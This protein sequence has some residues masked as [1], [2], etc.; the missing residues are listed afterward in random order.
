MHKFKAILRDIL[1]VSRLTKIPRKKV[2]I[3]FS[4]LVSNG[5]GF[6]D[7]FII[8][9]FSKF[10]TDTVIG[11]E[12]LDTITSS[13]RIIPLVVVFRYL[14]NFIGKYNIFSLTK[15][16]EAS[17]KTYILDEVYKKGNY[18]LADA[19]YYIEQL[20][21]H[22]AYFFNAAA[23]IT[24]SLIQIFVFTT[25]LSYDN[26][27]VLL[28][29][30]FLVIALFFPSKF[31]LTKSRQAMEQSY[32]YAYKHVSYIQRII[33]NIFLVKILNTHKKELIKFEDN[34][35]KFYKTEKRKYILNDINVTIPNFIAVMSFSILLI[36]PR[37]A[38]SITLE[39]IGV[40]LRL[41]QSL[42]SVNSALNGLI[43]S[44]VHLEKL[45]EIKNNQLNYDFEFELKP[46]NNNAI[47]LK[48]VNFSFLGSSEN[49]YEN[50]SISFEKNRHHILT[51]DNGSG[52]STL[53]GILTGA[54]K[55]SSGQGL[56]ASE[57]IGYI[58]AT[59]LILDDTLRE[60]LLYACTDEVDDEKLK[61]L[62]SDFKVFNESKDDVLN[63]QITNKTLS[64]G[65]MQKI[66]FIRAFVSECEILF[67]DEST[68]NL[69]VES[70]KLITEILKQKNITIINST[71]S[72]DD[73]DYD[74]HHKIFIKSGLTRSIKKIK[75]V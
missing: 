62:L 39:F 21:V 7:I 43:G 31:L 6:S 40:T 35:Y 36:V 52:K 47:E 67:L 57:K 16:I 66:S 33:D 73:F 22:I 14:L 26:L 55:P 53:L 29:L 10:L 32:Q 42:S 8:L 46:K 69:D 75:N 60:N 44:H 54:L 13:P 63:M 11:N 59:P 18:S 48:D 70:K 23:N 65:Q 64:S 28:L 27:E 72:P 9:T 19:T 30:V 24:T 5:I 15:D 25:F 38:K 74:T 68:S 2:R 12:L 51:G 71:H 56:K 37:Y 58:G 17:L 34:L 1:F 41:V 4:A 50:L 49:F 45:I 61:V 20:S 3:L